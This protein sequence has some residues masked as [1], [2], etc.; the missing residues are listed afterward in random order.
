MKLKRGELIPLLPF[1]LPLLHSLTA[2]PF[3]GAETNFRMRD[4]K[5][6]IQI[7]RRL[8]AFGF[9]FPV[10]LSIIHFPTFHFDA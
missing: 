8:I 3:G 4:L 1:S 9:P 6:A 5:G 7:R 2:D 10:S